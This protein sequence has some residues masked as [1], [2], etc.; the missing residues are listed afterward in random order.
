ME[1]H[2]IT[3]IQQERQVEYWMLQI[4]AISG[5]VCIPDNNSHEI[6]QG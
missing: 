3:K 6:L 1:A 2:Q 4:V 5:R